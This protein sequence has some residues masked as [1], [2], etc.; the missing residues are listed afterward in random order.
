MKESSL[1][2]LMACLIFCAAFFLVMMFVWTERDLNTQTFRQSRF[3]VAEKI[4]QCEAD[5]PRNQR[6]KVILTVE[7][8]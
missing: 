5:L 3:E 6:C 2:F 1:A 4:K 7:K 8:P